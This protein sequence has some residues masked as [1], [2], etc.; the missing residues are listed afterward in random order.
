MPTKQPAVYIM[1]SKPGGTIYIG[2]TSNLIRRVYQHRVGVLG[3]FTKKY[4]CKS[5]VY[6]ELSES[7]LE[8]IS[9]EKQLKG[10]SR[11]KKVDLIEAKNPH[12]K[13]LYKDLI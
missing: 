13:D 3:G 1:A 7:M 8:A 10:I 6:Y 11:K 5:L 12:W 2:V 9:R 4:E